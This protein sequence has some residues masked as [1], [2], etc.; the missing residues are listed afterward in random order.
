MTGIVIGNAIMNGRS[1]VLTLTITGHTVEHFDADVLFEIPKMIT[2]GLSQ[3]AGIGALPNTRTETSARV[4]I[5]RHLRDFEHQVANAYSV[6]QALNVDLYALIKSTDPEEWS[7]VTV[8]RAAELIS[9]KRHGHVASLFATHRYLMKHSEEFVPQSSTHRTMQTFD[10][11]PQSHLVKLRAVKDMIYSSNPAI[12]M[13]VSKA[14]IIM[15]ENRERRKESWD[16]PPT[17]EVDKSVTYTAEDRSIIDVLQHGLRRHWDVVTDPYSI[18]ISTILKKLQVP[19]NLGDTSV[20]QET[21]VDLGH[22]AP[23]ED[24]VSRRRELNLDQCPDTESTRVI[25]QNRIVERNLSRLPSV[26]TEPLG[27]EDFYPHDPVDHLRHDFGDMP[28][29]IVDDVG[30]EELDDGLSVEEI[31]SEPGSAWVHVHIADPTALI[32]PTH[33]FARQAYRQ[34]MTCYL[35]H[36]TWPMFPTSLTRSKLSL[37]SRTKYGEPEPVLTFS[38]KVDPVGNMVDYDVR[39]GLIRKVVAVDYDSLD[40]H[41]GTRSPA[42]ASRPFELDDQPGPTAV[43]ALGSEHTSNVRLLADIIIRH[44]MRNLNSSKAFIAVLPYAR[45]SIVQKP[46]YGAP[47]HSPDPFRFRGFPSISYQVLSQKIQETGSRMMIAECMK[48]A[49]RVASRWLT[50]RD[51]PMLR[52]TSKPPVPLG[53]SRALEKVLAARD[54]DGFVDFYLVQKANLH[55]PPVEHTLRPDMHW[56]MGVQDGEG[57]IRVT[58]PLRRYSDLVA[59]WQIKSALLHPTGGPVFSRQWLTGYAPEIKAK[60]RLFKEVERTHYAYWTALYLK[61]FM[62]DP[63]GV[64]ENPGFLGSLTANVLFKSVYDNEKGVHCHIPCLGLKAT[65]HV[66]SGVQIDVGDSLDVRIA[67]IQVGLRPRI[68]VVPK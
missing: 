29:Y 48:A 13:F 36:R 19:G 45:T 33:V 49:C 14:Q 37:G 12:D 58:S 34:G 1:V 24:V 18:V 32:P 20:L 4:E 39:A 60:E 50:D 22:L 42:Q 28:V 40:H 62:E 21:L 10:V 68:S 5:L 9:G 35:T 53:D 59:H 25:A 3:R 7:S 16:E 38:F 41:L 6:I 26:S 55:I 11:R 15:A 8:T 27:V 2:Y 65:L 57:Y 30:A 52:R 56:S 54:S 64:M 51:V 63:R 31:P 61:R 46:L 66:P 47:L 23:W 44:R 67:D 43:T 17:R